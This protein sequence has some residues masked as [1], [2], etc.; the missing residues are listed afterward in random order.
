MTHTHPDADLDSQSPT[1]NVPRIPRRQVLG[2]SLGLGLA[3]ATSVRSLLANH[4]V[5]ERSFSMQNQATPETMP[6]GESDLQAVSPALA[7]YREETLFGD[8]WNRPELSYRDRSIVTLAALITRNQTIE[9]ASYVNLALDSGVTPAEVSEVI[10]H[11]AFYA[12]WENAMT[13]VAVSRDVFAQRGIGA[14]QLPRPHPSS[15]RWMRRRRNSAQ[16]P[17]RRRSAP[18]PRGWW[19]T[20]VTSCSRTCGCAR[21]WHPAIGAW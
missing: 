8:L 20:P 1:S 3:V 21:T 7:R 19:T 15:C 12:G 14:D 6:G 16:P 11:L 9:M 5:P 13:A 2:A 18:S 10:T 17:F 4:A